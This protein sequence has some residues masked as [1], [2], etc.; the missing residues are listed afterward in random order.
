LSD[1][2]PEAEL[3]VVAGAPLDY[4]M[5]L[6]GPPDV[7]LVVEI[8]ESSVRWHRR[9]AAVYAAAGF[10]AHW[11]IDVDA[12]RVEVRTKPQQTGVYG[13]VEVVD[14]RGKLSLPALKTSLPV[15]KLLP[16]RRR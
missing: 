2:L 3:A 7:A 9:K 5:R 15:T 4:E 1:S 6:P 12:R 14:E 8:A 11:L 13:S 16:R 10:R